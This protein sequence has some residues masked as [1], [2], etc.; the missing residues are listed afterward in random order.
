[1]Q[2]ELQRSRRV[3]GFSFGG[4]IAPVLLA[5]EPRL[6]AAILS[7]GGLHYER[8]LPEADGTNFATRV[9]LPLLM[10]NG[11]Y[12]SLFP[13]DPSQLAIFRRVATSEKDK[14]HVIYESGH[15]A[16]PLGEEVR[17]TLDW[18]D[19]YLGPVHR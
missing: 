2:L 19:K 18:L 14:R 9:H 6:K 8:S 13:V 11:R 15:G 3:Y 17:E 5:I 1:M 10:L 16:L 12:D 7:S 4:V